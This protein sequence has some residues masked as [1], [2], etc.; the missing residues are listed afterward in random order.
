[1]SSESLIERTTT[2]AVEMIIAIS[3]DTV[4]VSPIETQ[5]NM[6]T[7]NGAI[8]PNTY[9]R[10]KGSAKTS[11]FVNAKH[12]VEETALTISMSLSARGMSFYRLMPLLA[13]ITIV[14][15][16]HVTL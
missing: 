3:A 13:A 15:T 8:A 11:R 14:K 2:P 1:M 9:T 16:R 7:K 5:A 6:S 10:S 4:I 12:I